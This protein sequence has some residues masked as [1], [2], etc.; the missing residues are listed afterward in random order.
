MTASSVASAR[1]LEERPPAPDDG[2]PEH[3]LLGGATGKSDHQHLLHVHR[4]QECGG[5]RGRDSEPGDLRAAA[6]RDH[7]QYTRSQDTGR[8]DMSGFIEI[9]AIQRSSAESSP[10]EPPIS[11]MRSASTISRLANRARRRAPRTSRSQSAPLAPVAAS[12]APD[13]SSSARSAPRCSRRIRA[14]AARSGKTMRIC[15]S[16]R[17][18]R[19]NAGSSFPASLQAANKDNPLAHPRRRSRLSSAFTT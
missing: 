13:R 18:L 6:E 1:S 4:P 15:R 14:S 16:S 5:C 17:P 12:A 11:P 10:E 7:I 9:A 3:L 19:I 2:T 8:N